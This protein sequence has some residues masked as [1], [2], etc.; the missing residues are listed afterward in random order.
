MTTAIAAVIRALVAT[1]TRPMR[2]SALAWLLGLTLTVTGAGTAA[3]QT[4]PLPSWNE[5]AVKE[6]ILKFVQGVTDRA[7]A[8]YVPAEA[9]QNAEAARW[10]AGG[11]PALRVER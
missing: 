9:R 3:A 5:G 11:R 6:A 8:R 1:G 4:D 7:S 10:Q 2:R